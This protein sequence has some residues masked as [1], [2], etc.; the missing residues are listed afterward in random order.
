MK[1]FCDINIITEFL[2]K[3]DNKRIKIMTPQ[4]FVDEF[5]SNTPS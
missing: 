1:I 2:E 4:S 5:L 3:K